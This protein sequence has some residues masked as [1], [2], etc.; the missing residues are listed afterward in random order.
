MKAGSTGVEN[1]NFEYS[2]SA[3]NAKI[4]QTVNYVE[5]I[6]KQDNNKKV[7]I[8]LALKGKEPE[9]GKEVDDTPRIVIR[10]KEEVWEE[11]ADDVVTDGNKKKLTF[12]FTLTVNSKETELTTVEQF[13]IELE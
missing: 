10:N 1:D 9:D 13:E 5:D 7:P 8:T 6:V 3:N 4:I 12:K 2:L 11:F